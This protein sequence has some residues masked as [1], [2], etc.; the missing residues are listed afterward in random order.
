[1]EKILIIRFSSI[2]DIVL[3]SPVIRCIK[4]QKNIRIHYLVKSEYRI[5][6]DS[7]PHIEKV[8]SFNYNF[9]QLIADLKSEKYDLII[10]L[11][12]NFRSWWIKFNLS[13]PSYSFKKKNWKKYLLIYGNWNLLNNHVV[14]RYFEVVKHINITNDNHGLEYFFHESTHVD[15][16]ID[17][18][19]IAW[20]IGASSIKKQLSKKQIIDVCNHIQ[21]PVVLLGG[22]SE[23]N[24]GKKIVQESD[25]QKIYNF[26]GQTDLDQSAYI[27][28]HSSLV[29]SNDTG[30]MHIAA[31][32]KKPII[33]F[34]GCTKPSLGFSPYMSSDQSKELITAKS[35]KPCSR[36][37]HYCRFQGDG[38]VKEISS[39]IILQSIPTECN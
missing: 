20:S 17:Q 18:V 13:L 4:N 38:C 34:W 19:F 24:L 39:K 28:K 22:L 21:H 37:G 10:D 26:C 3:T 7:N 35:D 30:L 16:D 8:F 12:N 9:N 23:K 25:H 2:G 33:S 15:F 29:L 14:D 31:A 11:Q 32:F 6:V 36:H 27:I 5:L 1:M